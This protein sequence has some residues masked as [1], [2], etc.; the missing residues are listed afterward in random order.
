MKLL[1]C[2]TEVGMA[3]SIIDFTLVGFVL[4]PVALITCPRYSICGT[5]KTYLALLA[6]SLCDLSNYNTNLRWVTCS[7]M[8]LL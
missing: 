5:A 8:D 6:I 4:T 1:S 2:V 7:D 3:H